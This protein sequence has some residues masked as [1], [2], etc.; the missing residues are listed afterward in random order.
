MNKAEEKAEAKVLKR[1]QKVYFFVPIHYL[2]TCLCLY[3]IY[4][5][6]FFDNIQY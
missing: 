6:E 4:I 5:F 2:I 1:N 3:G